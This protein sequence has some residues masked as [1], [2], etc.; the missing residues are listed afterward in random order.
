MADNNQ[1]ELN[2]FSR[3]TYVDLTQAAL[4]GTNQAYAEVAR[5]TADLMLPALNEHALGQLM[6]MLMLAT[7]V[8][9]RLMGVNPYGQPGVQAYKQRMREILKRTENKSSVPGLSPSVLGR[10]PSPGEAP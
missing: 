4:L 6:Q 1:D 5:P 8:E 3:R 7:V 2:S 10:R 9:G